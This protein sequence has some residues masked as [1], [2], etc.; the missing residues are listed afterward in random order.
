MELVSL[1]AG[2]LNQNNIVVTT[3]IYISNV[4]VFTFRSGWFMDKNSVTGSSDMLTVCIANDLAAKRLGH[5][6]QAN[7]VKKFGGNNSY[8]S[9][10]GRKYKIYILY[11]HYDFS[12][13]KYPGNVFFNQ[14]HVYT[15][16]K[17][18]VGGVGHGGGGACMHTHTDMNQTCFL[19]SYVLRCCIKILR[20]KVY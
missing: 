8:I 16:Y 17:L 3:V 12:A 9:K 15:F 13:L 2:T 6:Q 4:F 1:N 7:I 14:P 19:Q 10:Y 11:I 18:R 20:A 5:K